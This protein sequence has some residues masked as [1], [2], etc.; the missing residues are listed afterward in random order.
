[1]INPTETNAENPFP[2]IYRNGKFHNLKSMHK[3]KFKS[4]LKLLWQ[5]A[6]KKK[7]NTRPKGDIPLYKLTQQE[8]LST[9]NQSL[10]RLGH[11]TVLMKL[12]NSF[13]ITD[14]VFSLRASPLQWVGM[15]RFHNPPISIEELPPLKAVV[16]SHN[17]YDHLDK[18]AILKLKDKVEHFLTPRGVGDILIKWGVAPE[19]V[20]QFDWWD[21]VTLDQIEYVFTPAQH[22]SGRSLKDN[23]KTLWGSWCIKSPEQKIFFSGD[24]GYFPGFKKIGELHGPFDITLMETGA[25]NKNWPD[26]HMQ[27]EQSLQ[28]HIDLKGKWYLPIHNSTFDLAL[29]AWYEPLERISELAHAK[30]IPLCTPII[31]EAVSLNKLTPFPKWWE[32]VD[33]MS[34]ESKKVLPKSIH[35]ESDYQPSYLVPET[36]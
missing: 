2:S 27:P 15:K 3:I 30:A 17:H 24:T 31:G 4:G 21:A 19:K 6:T 35:P 23:N 32:G 14:P 28:A 36:P 12:Q 13:I 20:K 22:F 29:H 1:M 25:Y 18:A 34:M 11:S 26:V 16:I 33:Q 7:R 8:L 5:I 9:P 10:F